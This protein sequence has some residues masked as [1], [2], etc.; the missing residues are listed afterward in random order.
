METDE[1]IKSFLDRNPEV[2]LAD[3][4]IV[5]VLTSALPDD[6]P[7]VQ[8]DLQMEPLSSS[9]LE[10][11][12]YEDDLARWAGVTHAEL[13]R[14]MKGHAVEYSIET[15]LKYGPA[16]GFTPNEIKFVQEHANLI[17]AQMEVDLEA[18]CGRITLIHNGQSAEIRTLPVAQTLHAGSTDLP[19]SPH[20]M[21]T[22]VSTWTGGACLQ[23][24][25]TAEGWAKAL[26]YL[27]RTE[28][29]PA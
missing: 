3:G 29:D 5:P 21:L 14:M 23:Y 9:S 26:T 11:A 1:K 28:G 2:M 4:R 13:C 20:T 12:A 17:G 6:P 8:I 24:A 18:W 25:R 19:P 27:W 10:Q 22:V 15:A 16:C 7:T